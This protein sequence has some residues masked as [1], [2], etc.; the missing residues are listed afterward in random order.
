MLR[1]SDRPHSP[2]DPEDQFG[3]EWLEYL[4]RR[5]AQEAQQKLKIL[6]ANGFPQLS[7]RSAIRKL[8]ALNPA[9]LEEIIEHVKSEIGS[10]E[11]YVACCLC[12]SPGEPTPYRAWLAEV[13]AADRRALADTIWRRFNQSDHPPEVFH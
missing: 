13:E 10:R 11:D 1:E 5:T 3:V 7:G 9:A 8:R 4:L 12:L 2:G 6:V